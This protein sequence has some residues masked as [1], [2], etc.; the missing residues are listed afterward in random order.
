MID[1]Q[2]KLM[3]MIHRPRLVIDATRRLMRL[4]EV[5]EVP[6]LLT[7]QY[8]EGLGPTHPEIAAT[9]EELAVEKRRLVKTSFGCCGD[10]RFEELLGELRPAVPPERRQLRAARLDGQPTALVLSRRIGFP[11]SVDARASQRP[12][13]FEIGPP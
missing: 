10:A 13:G 7:E 11:A 3:E 9:Y 5:F 8:P 1:L 12:R 4:A 2:G 6:V